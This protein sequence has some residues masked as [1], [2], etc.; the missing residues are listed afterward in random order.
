MSRRH[1]P[2]SRRSPDAHR[3]MVCEPDQLRSVLDQ[4]DDTEFGALLARQAE[5]Y[6][7]QVPAFALMLREARR[8]LLVKGLVDA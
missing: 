7:D 3:I 5:R 4:I 6:E 8:R 2:P 1:K